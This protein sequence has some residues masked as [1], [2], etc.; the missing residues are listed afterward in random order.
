MRRHRAELLDLRMVL[1]LVLLTF[2]LPT[3]ARAESFSDT[4][5]FDQRLIADVVGTALAFMAPRILEPESTAQLAIWGLRG[6][7]TLDSR[8]VAT[9]T[10]QTLTLNLA[11]KLLLTM[12]LPGNDSRAWGEAVA[13]LARAGWD[14]SE[15]VRHAGATGVIGAFFDELF[16][17][18]DPYSRYAT[19]REASE[20]QIRRNGRAGVGLDIGSVGKNF[21][22]RAIA[23][24]SPAAR[25]DIKPGDTLSAI[26]GLSLYDADLNAVSA[27]LAGPEDSPVVVSVR[28]QN[29]PVRQIELRRAI[30]TPPTVFANR[31]HDL[32][33]LRITGFA[34]N[35]AE[36]LGGELV[37]GLATPKPPKAVVLDLRGNRGGLLRQ[38]VAV[39][40]LML[41]SGLLASTAGRDP[42][43]HHEFRAAGTDLTHGLPLILL[44]DGRTASAAEVL[45]AALADQHRAVVVGSATLGK[46]L[47][48]TI[49]PLPDGGALSLT[50]SRVLAP[51]GW[52]LQSLGVLPQV[53][54]S[55][56][57]DNLR[58]QLAELALGRQP[59]Q[60]AVSRNREARPPLLP[61]EVLEIR[62]ACPASEGRDSD[63]MAAKFLLDTPQAYDAALIRAPVAP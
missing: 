59:M 20:E 12:K 34:R 40:E 50:W 8:L 7:N 28:T 54:T 55:L 9:A 63:M 33:V 43:A 39:A 38:A 15:P 62:N 13:A 10:Q 41:P 5:N 18:L 29:R 49:L 27:L 58:R 11:G 51:Q 56:G 57:E 30:L 46:G 19:P 14:S 6:L 22:V 44:V 52:P 2:V 3:R 47:V 45:A 61:A 35:T 17:H 37:R 31:D 16:N 48:Q 32:L 24:A 60:R 53:C 1:L 26:D 25:T 36:S 21:I 4:A 42:A 23:P